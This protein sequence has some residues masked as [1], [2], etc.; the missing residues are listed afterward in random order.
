[1]DKNGYARFDMLGIKLACP[2]SLLDQGNELR[3]LI[4]AVASLRA[5]Q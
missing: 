2:L 5:E 1:M 3:S 4:G